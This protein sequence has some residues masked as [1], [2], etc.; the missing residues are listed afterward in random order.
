M[1]DFL[2]NELQIGD[3]VAFTRPGYRGLCV[4]KILAFTPKSI[5]VEYTNNWNYSDGKVDTFL[6]STSGVYKV[7]PKLVNTT[8]KETA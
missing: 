7:D 2:G 3:F 4:G 1:R 5:R 6:T 8:Q